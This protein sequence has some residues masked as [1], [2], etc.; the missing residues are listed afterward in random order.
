MKP[1]KEKR[2]PRAIRANP[3]SAVKVQDGGRKIARAQEVEV[4]PIFLD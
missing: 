4:G 3:G 1:R 2:S